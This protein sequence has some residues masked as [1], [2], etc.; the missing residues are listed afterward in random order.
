[1][2]AQDNGRV[3]GQ[4]STDK[5]TVEELQADVERQREELAETVEQL[6][7]KADVKGRAKARISDTTQ[8]ARARAADLVVRGRDAATT[9]EGRPTPVALA[10]AAGLVTAVV[11]T[12]GL[13]V[14]RR[15]R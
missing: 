12:V 11:V 13:V 3:E 2:T 6:T 14:W 15:R 7:A 5:P 9:P 4:A 8:Q 10:A 1:V